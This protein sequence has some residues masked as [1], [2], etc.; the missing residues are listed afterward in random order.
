MKW[1]DNIDNALRNV[2]R[3]AGLNLTWLGLTALGLGVLGLFPATVALF[4]VARQWVLGDTEKPLLAM[5]WKQ[6]WACFWHANLA[7]WAITSVGTVL[8]LNYQVI[9][10]ADGAVPMMMVLSFLAVSLLFGLLVSVLLPI[11]SHYDAPAGELIK[12]ATCFALGRLPVAIL[13]P[14]ILW[15]MGWLTLALPAFFLFFSGSV[16]AY[17]LM[18]L[19]THSIKRLI[20]TNASALQLKL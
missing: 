17:T 7:G 3:F 5:A 9:Q 16:T 1:F 12:K 2:T 15:T 4:H 10:A 20:A 6:Y 8:Y 19:F 11:V 18:W 14:L 13:F